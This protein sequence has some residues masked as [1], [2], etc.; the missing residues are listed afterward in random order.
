MG[1]DQWAHAASLEAMAGQKR[2]FHLSAV[3]SGDGYRLSEALPSAG[4]SVIQTLDLTD[5]SDVDRVAPGGN[6]LDKDLDTW[7]SIEY[8]SDPLTEPMELSGLFD[9]K[10]DIQTNKKDFDLYI[11]LYEVT[12]D[13]RY[14]Q[15]SW[16]LARASYVQDR[17][18]RHLLVPG[19]RQQLSFRNSRLTSLRLQK[20]SRL[21][22]LVSL[23]RQ[24]SAEIDY[25]TGKDVADETVTDAKEPLKIQWFDDSYIDL[26]L[27]L[28]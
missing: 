9:G 3:K 13:G 20:G 8:I 14:F 25:G 24:P 17:S 16:Y 21:L 18:Q 7:N 27:H 11:G 10:L 28:P 1:A 5:R 19:E 15:L 2:R 26:P 22:V 12:P 6:I 4:A 23:I